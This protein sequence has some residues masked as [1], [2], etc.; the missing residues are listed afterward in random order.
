M[1]DEAR[2]FD[3]KEET[4]GR[5]V[6]PAREA[7]GPLQRIEGAVDLDRIESAARE[8]ELARMRQTLR[9][10]FPPPRR[11]GPARDADANIAGHGPP[12]IAS[13]GLVLPA[14]AIGG[15]PLAICQGRYASPSRRRHARSRESRASADRCRRK[16]PRRGRARPARW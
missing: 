1:G 2:P 9:I 4:L 5:R 7:F 8:S 10:E 6:E 3:G 14:G 11:I 16:T 12:D 15:V 13:L